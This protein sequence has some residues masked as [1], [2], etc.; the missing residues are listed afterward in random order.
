MG[1]YF[2]RYEEFRSDNKVKPVPGL[3]I[4]MSTT[5]KKVVFKSNSRMDILSQ[6]YYASPY[7]GWLIML[8]NQQF[9]GSEFDI[10][11]N[12]IIRVPFPLKSAID[13]YIVSIKEHKRLN[14]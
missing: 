9:G 7:Y 14:G 12:E 5:D 10:P 2:D 13:R 1:Q 8:C 4:P 11:S 3:K 6:E